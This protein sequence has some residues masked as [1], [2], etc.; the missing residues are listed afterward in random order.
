MSSQSEKNKRHEMAET[1]TW[2]YK[3][4]PPFLLT[5]ITTA[6]YYPSLNYPFQFDDLANITKNFEIRL[7]KPPVR[8]FSGR[9]LGETLNRINYSIGKFDPFYYRSFNL[10]IHLLTGLTL[11]YLVFKLCKN[12]KQSSILY[13]NSIFTAFITSGIFLLHPVQTQ[14]ISYVVQARLEGLAGLF[15]LLSV[16]LFI[17]YCQSKR[18]ISK[19]IFLV[20]LL[21]NGFLSCGTKEIIIVSPLLLI[22][23]DWFIISEQSWQAFKKRIFIHVLF[24]LVVF[25][26]F[27]YFLSLKWF[28]HFLS[29]QH[30]TPN[31]TGN[32]LT[33]S[34]ND[35]IKP[36]DYFISEFKVI[37][38]YLIIYIWPFNLSVEYDWKLSSSIFAPDSFFPL[39]ILL[40]IAAFIIRNTIKKQ[41][42]PLNF[43]LLWF[44]IA[45]APRSSIVPSPELICDYKAYLPSVGWIFVLS[46]GLVY[47][48]NF[49][50]IKYKKKLPE[51]ISFCFILSAIAYSVV[52]GI[53]VW[54]T[55]YNMKS[56]IAMLFIIPITIVYLVYYILK[57][58]QI[59][60]SARNLMLFSM[61]FLIPLGYGTV[62][63]NIVWSST[64]EFWS[65]IVNKAPLKARG[66]NNYG[67]GLSESGRV[68]EAIKHYKEAIRL[69]G[70]YC[71]PYSNLAVAYSL[72]GKTD[73]AIQALKQALK[74]RPNYPEA[75]NN[76]GSFLLQKK[77]YKG[78]EQCFNLAIQL[79][80]WYGKAHLNL[81][82]LFLEKNE[83]DKAWECAI[84]A[85]KG[86]LDN[87]M[88]FM[89]LGEV[90]IKLQK[91][92][93]AIKALKQ[94]IA[95]GANNPKVL[96][97]IANAYYME[98]QYDTAIQYYK[99]LQQVV[100][101]NPHYLYNLG[102]A[103]FITG[104]FAAALETFKQAKEL[105]NAVPQTHIRIANCCEKLGDKNTAVQYLTMLKQAE[106]PDWFKKNIETE[107]ERL[108]EE[109]K[110]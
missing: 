41:Y 60:Y 106:S 66:H 2:W 3:I 79:R 21:I 38:H 90:A 96:F 91:Y 14:A 31:N 9:W 16:L 53:I 50:T 110:V 82:R 77:D 105:P 76:L 47:L 69:D 32:I 65:D 40:G 17:Q 26:T 36:Y 11:F 67:V 54:Q 44:F 85:T 83:K 33:K 19:T 24:S 22:I 13:K 102:E 87:D 1:V 48:I 107:L 42:G 25:G 73:Q 23:T 101:N 98:K 35:L 5:I 74:L 29:L 20:L 52:I 10:I 89:A 81:G 63:R 103:Y 93:E 108:N 59:N 58:R 55:N 15:G 80:P 46:A 28:T 6:F 94:A 78:A 49:V 51:I 18:L 99:H 37:L 62:T 30:T 39:L 71:D 12:L 56:F 84:N 7:L 92:S 61:L 43:G 68:L 27:A 4:I 45:I 88:G 57:N 109:H 34:A 95:L 72:T 86:D 64:V 8:I 104:N 75:Y 70:D 97:N 100:P